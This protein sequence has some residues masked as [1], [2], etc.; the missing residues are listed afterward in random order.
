MS[1]EAEN[2]NVQLEQ[3]STSEAE[4]EED[5]YDESEDAPP[6]ELYSA[7]SFYDPC[8][9][10]TTQI[11]FE[12]HAGRRITRLKSPR[13]LYGVSSA[14]FLQLPRWP[15]ECQ[16]LKESIQHIEWDPPVPEPMYR[17]T[18]LEQ[19]PT[20][21]DPLE[22]KVIYQ[23][24][25][26]WKESFFMCSR[27]GGNRSPLK[28]ASSHSCGEPESSLVFE[29][30]FESGNLQKV[31]QVGE[32]DY[33]LTLRTDLYTNRHTQWYYFRVKN[34]KASVPYRFTII[35][36]MKPNSL[37]NHGMR[38]LLYSEIEA[39]T[40]QIGWHR[41]GEDI[42]YY[43]NSH[44]QNGQTYYSL[45]WTFKFPHSEDVCYFAYCYPY[46]YSN[47]QDYLS[48]IANDPERSR[49]CKIR[50]LC[51]SLAGNIVYVLTITNSSTSTSEPKKKKAVIV[52]ARVH[53]GETNSSWVMKGFLDFIL[54]SR[55]DAHLL[56]DIFVFKVVPMLNPDGVIVGNYRCSLTGRDLNRNYKTRLKDSFPSIW[57]TRNMIKRVME[58]REILLYCDL[59]GHSR[60]QN[61]FMYGCKGKGGQNGGRRL[62]ER[63]FPFML[64]KN[65]PDKFSFSG[66]KFKVQKNKEGTGRVVMW[67][68]GIHNSYTLEATFGGSTLGSRRGTH[69]STKDLESVGHS[70]CSALLDYCDQ[71]HSKYY[72]C[73]DELEDLVKQK[74][75]HRLSLGSEDLLDVLSDLDSST[76]GSDS[77]DSNG[78]P[79]H[80]MELVSKVKPRKKQLKSKRDRNSQRKQ[81]DQTPF[82]EQ[83]VKLG[84]LEKPLKCRGGCRRSVGAT[85]R[86]KREPL[87]RDLDA[88]KVSVIYLMFNANGQVITTKTHPRARERNVMEF[89]SSLQGFPWNRPHPLF[90][91][92]VSQR[93]PFS[94]V[95]G[96]S[97]YYIIPTDISDTPIST[98]PSDSGET[99]S[100]DGMQRS[101][102]HV[103]A[104]LHSEEKFSSYKS[105]GSGEMA[106]EGDAG[107]SVP[108]GAVT[109]QGL[110]PLYVRTR[111]STTPPAPAD[112]DELNDHHSVLKFSEDHNMRWRQKETCS[113]VPMKI[114]EQSGSDHWKEGMAM[115]ELVKR[116]LT[117]PAVSN[118]KDAKTIGGT[119]EQ[120]YLYPTSTN[121]R[122]VQNSLPRMA[123]HT[124]KSSSTTSIPPPRKLKVR[125]SN[126]MLQRRK[127][128]R[129]SYP[130]PKEEQA[131]PDR[132][133]PSLPLNTWKDIL[134]GLEAGGGEA[135]AASIPLCLENQLLIPSAPKQDIRKE[136]T[137]GYVTLTKKPGQRG[138]LVPLS[139]QSRRSSNSDFGLKPS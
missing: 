38:P 13:D 139:K 10:R 19:E 33:Q 92:L 133:H 93:F 34:T 72:T 48:G 91:S 125:S 84:S 130:H 22:C 27:V 90:K 12:Y 62:C 47:L 52:T 2:L 105:L 68:M 86:Q 95:L 60:K 113:S 110:L 3:T 31:V 44:G 56:R 120:N 67:K 75:N 57:F 51:H 21:V 17:S 80:L 30:R 126:G 76:G 136:R 6:Y 71:G 97:C 58:E 43:K 108:P 88:R 7:G 14:S 8:P 117:L 41:I 36:F 50:V 11:V 18:G 45:S 116:E 37:Y 119:E 85:S 28:S 35:N 54:S 32:H 138:G 82:H 94:G 112:M 81:F 78:P 114:A 115:T 49:Y 109:R 5:P 77:S 107:S 39:E 135:P 102:K 23:L 106:L 127:I 111:K 73:L 69:F 131:I 70:F 59:H 124:S 9:Q 96:P 104:S 134:I 121:I 100:G 42:K 128:G 87:L 4:S 26:A 20:Y 46:T 53:P 15:Y 65:S 66:C 98:H 89:T 122:H 74:V 25:E 123:D 64:S 79:A 1:D 29:S 99:E 118:S 63:I 40:K 24:S 137:N 101:G 61:V 16:V 83:Q 129:P 103:L 132:Q 55:G